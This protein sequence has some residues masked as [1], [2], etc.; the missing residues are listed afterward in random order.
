VSS[1]SER[2]FF[3]RIGRPIL[4]IKNQVSFSDSSLVIDYVLTALVFG[5]VSWDC[6]VIN[7]VV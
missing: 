5:R 1:Q 6:V 7:L 2:C 3:K 4:S